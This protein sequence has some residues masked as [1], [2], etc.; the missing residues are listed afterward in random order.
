VIGKTIGQLQIYLR[1]YD[2]WLDYSSD[3]TGLGILRGFTYGYYDS[4]KQ[5]GP[6]RYPDC[7]PWKNFETFRYMVAKSRFYTGR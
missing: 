1:K 3:V 6:E 2:W 5:F 7:L 4:L